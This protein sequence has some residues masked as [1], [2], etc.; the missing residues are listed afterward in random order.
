MVFLQGVH[1][2]AMHALIHPRL[3]LGRI[4]GCRAFD[5]YGFRRRHGAR[6]RPG[7]RSLIEILPTQFG[8]RTQST[9]ARIIGPDRSGL[10]PVAT[11][12]LRVR[13]MLAP[14]PWWFWR[15]ACAAAPRGSACR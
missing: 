2:G 9:V 12:G 8:C 14:S 7:S 10:R 3:A 15:E 4:A 5:R 13:F 6:D 11:Q 1:Y